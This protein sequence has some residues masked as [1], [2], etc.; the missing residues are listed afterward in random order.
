[1]VSLVLRMVVLRVLAVPRPLDAVAE[2]LHTLQALVSVSPFQ[3]YDYREDGLLTLGLLYGVKYRI[4][5][6]IL[7]YTQI[8]RRF[9][10]RGPA[11]YP[12]KWLLIQQPKSA[13]ITQVNPR[14]TLTYSYLVC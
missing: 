8:Y 1:M 10:R 11:S 2:D 7:H 4:R 13:D 12:T 5:P 9:G 3:D 6:H 14:P